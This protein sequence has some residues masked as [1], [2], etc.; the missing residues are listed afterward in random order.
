M[1]D[2]YEVLSPWA[3]ADPVLL[4]GLAERVPSLAGK[5]VGLFQDIK[6]AAKPI[7][8]V[9]E[10]KLREQYPDIQTTWYAP[11]SMS[12]SELDLKNIDKFHDWVKGV[13]AVVAA[14]GD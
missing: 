9:V 1:G 8:T 2:Q 3:V 7:L 11:Q 6:R 10:W 4:R 14:V 13:D 5:K 12:A